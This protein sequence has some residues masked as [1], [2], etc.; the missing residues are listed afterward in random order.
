[1]DSINLILLAEFPGRQH[2][3]ELLSQLISQPYQ[4]GVPFLY[5]NG[6]TATGKTSIISRFFELYQLEFQNELLQTDLTNKKKIIPNYAIID[7]TECTS[8]KVLFRKA[9]KPWLGLQNEYTTKATEYTKCDTVLDN[10]EKLRDLDALFIPSLLQ[11]TDMIDLSIIMLSSTTWDNIRPLATTSPEPI[12]IYFTQ[13]TKNDILNILKFDCPK[14]EPIPFFCTFVDSLHETFRRSCI[15]LNELR[16]IVL[17]LYPKYVQ[18]VFEGQATRN[19]TARLFKLCQPYFI[20]AIDKLHLREISSYEWQKNSIQASAK[21]D[22]EKIEKSISNMLVDT[23]VQE[24]PYLTKYL[25][26]SSFISSF[27]PPKLDL[28]YFAKTTEKKR[29][30]KRGITLLKDSRGGKRRQ[31]LIGP[32]AFPLDRMLAI[33][34]KLLD[35]PGFPTIDLYTQISSLVMLKL[36]I[37]SSSEESLDSIKYKCNF[38]FEFVSEISKSVGFEIGKFLYDF[39]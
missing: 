39:C 33:F 12:S 16:R 36:L 1:M 4:T 22:Y 32:K 18:P 11:I 8:T 7:C 37:K 19:E 29:R 3:I 20:E 2:Q 28:Q 35:F 25:L 38:S 5:I 27:N 23:G 30:V 15:D 9:L 26:I 13:Y 6:H 14:D 21:N 24:F 10:A 31:Q 17:L 34:Y